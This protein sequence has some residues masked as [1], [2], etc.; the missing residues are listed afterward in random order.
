M[1]VSF[2]LGLSYLIAI[3]ALF[4]LVNIWGRDICTDRAEQNIKTQLRN[5][6][7]RLSDTTVSNY[8]QNTGTISR[9]RQELQH[10]DDV[11]G[12][13]IWLANSDGD[14]L[15]DSA[16]GV[17]EPTITAADYDTR[18]LE[19]NISENVIIGKAFEEPMLVS[20]EPFMYNYRAA[21]YICAFM[22]MSRMNQ[23]A[24]SYV[25][26]MNIG[27]L[28]IFLVLFIIFVAIYLYT[29][30]PIKTIKNAASEYAK[31]NY[32]HEMVIKSHDEFKELSDTIAYMVSEL[33]SNE[34]KQ[35]KFIANISHDFRSPLTSIKGYAEALKD[36]TIPYEN[37]DKYLDI[38]QFESERLH[39]LT[40]S[41]LQLSSIDSGGLSLDIK[42]FDIT[43]VI[44]TIA[45]AFEGTCRNKKI[46][47]KLKFDEPKI[48]VDADQARI[49]QVIYNLTDNAIKFS[50][51]DSEIILGV[52]I[53]GVKAV[54]RVKDFGLGIPKE[55]INRVFE[56]FYKSD[57]SRGKDKKG[58]GLGLSIAK[59]IITAHDEEIRVISNEG[60][61]TEFSFTLPIS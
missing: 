2:K 3:A 47:I 41:L 23:E 36:G 49:E 54:V 17:K 26:M 5:M 12:I 51:K 9:I 29:A 60:A 45:D 57:P 34:E 14:V 30:I 13:R 42:S 22:P 53:K 61:G 55:S 7:S 32:D 40:S 4:A 24:S 39:K 58:T 16:L 27:M 10:M 52:Q 35:R 19:Q 37:K 21:G 44:R 43:K 46:V 8:Y 48:F 11:T 20:S 33:K 31:G 50:N 18:I 56:R 59:E 6:V 25:E 28:I 1:R 15:A 38:I